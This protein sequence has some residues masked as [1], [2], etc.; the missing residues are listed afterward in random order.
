MK[1]SKLFS[2][3]STVGYGILIISGLS[4]LIAMIVLFRT[5][6]NEGISAA[7]EKIV[8]LLIAVLGG[9]YAVIGIIPLTLRLISIRKKSV[10]LPVFCLP[11]DLAYLVANALLL[12]QLLVGEAAIEW[13]GLLIFVA[14]V[15]LSLAIFILNIGSIFLYAKHK[16][17]IPDGGAKNQN[18]TENEI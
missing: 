9:A 3:V 5:A 2:I 10:L 4:L 17:A 7:L 18:E 14:L 6:G 1:K 16:R 8:A 13:W 15:L 11:F 12:E